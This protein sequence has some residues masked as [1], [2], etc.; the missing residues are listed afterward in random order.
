[1]CTSH[2]LCKDI[3]C[4]YFFD[5]YIYILKWSGR[6]HGHIVSQY[7]KH[8]IL[9]Y[10]L[11]FINQAGLVNFLKSRDLPSTKICPLDLQSKDRQLRNSDLIMTYMIMIVGLCA[12]SAIFIGEVGLYFHL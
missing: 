11:W 3:S 5:D 8:K 12:A 1:M 9:T 7:F 10:R 2:T 4:F 6:L